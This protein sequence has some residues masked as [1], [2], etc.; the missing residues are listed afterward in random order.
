MAHKASF[1]YVMSLVIAVLACALPVGG[2]PTPTPSPTPSPTPTPTPRPTPYYQSEGEQ[3]GFVP[4]D[5][6][7]VVLTRQDVP[8]G[9]QVFYPEGL[10]E[11]VEAYQSDEYR[12]QYI[13][14][15]LDLETLEFVGAGT[16]LLPSSVGQ[17]SF[18]VLMQDPQFVLDL[19]VSEG[20]LGYIDEVY[21]LEELPE[22]D[23]I[24]EISTGVTVLAE[25]EGYSPFRQDVV[26]FRRGMLGVVVFDSYV[27]ALGASVAVGE[28][29]RTLDARA[30][31]ALP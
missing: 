22:M 23:D 4:P 3:G 20:M 25:V 15:F 19:V 18:D 7:S 12:V 27:D 17:T 9:F 28:L 6:S 24:G 8:P 1:I 16:V 21:G 14:T 11:A 31:E 30:V 26:V 10:D 29:A 2:T 5:V 13:N